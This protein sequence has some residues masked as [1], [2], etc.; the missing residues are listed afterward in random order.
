MNCSAGFQKSSDFVWLASDMK[1][2][3]F[4]Q[5]LVIAHLKTMF[6]SSWKMPIYMETICL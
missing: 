2:K 3:S 1:F 6:E 4:V 5:S